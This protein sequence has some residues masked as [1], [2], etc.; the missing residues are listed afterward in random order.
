M[1]F[2]GRRPRWP[3]FLWSLFIAFEERRLRRI[4]NTLKRLK[5][6]G[7]K[8]D[9]FT[10]AERRDYG[11]AYFDLRKFPMDTKGPYLN[12]WDAYTVSFPTRL[13]NLIAAYEDYPNRV[14]GMESVFYW[15]RIWL[16]LD[17]DLKEEIDN[18][19]A[20]ADSAVYTSFSLL[21]DGLLF[22][23]YAILSTRY[24]SPIQALPGNS[25]LW[26]ASLVSL[27]AGYVI[28]RISI[29]VHA[30]FGEFFKSVFDIYGKEV[31]L[32]SAIEEVAELTGDSSL[33][34]L[35][36]KDKF[37]IAR[38]YLQFYVIKCRNCG[39]LISPVDIKK[40]KC[41]S[42]QIVEVDPSRDASISSIVVLC[43]LWLLG[44]VIRSMRHDSKRQAGR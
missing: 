23:L 34:S 30:Q 32:S 38:R 17:K 26:S 15:N 7:K 11:E 33:T 28:Y 19:Q 10:Q 44:K 35:N 1:L 18:Q 5:E 8:P 29:H 24:T 22:A 40:H 13:G 42:P 25:T 31:D 9:E 36:R 3:Q 43:F 14:Y 6:T 37:K 20:V 39:E 21:V 16:K 12:P 41:S 27:V 4:K 2:E